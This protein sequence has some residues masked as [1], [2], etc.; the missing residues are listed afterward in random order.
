[1]RTRLLPLAV[2]ASLAPFALGSCVDAP[3]TLAIDCFTSLDPMNCAQGVKASCERLAPGSVFDIAIF[4]V[5]D[6]DGNPIVPPGVAGIASDG[7]IAFPVVSNHAH[8]TA[9]MG[10]VNGL[11]MN[12]KAFEVT[13]KPGPNAKTQN[14]AKLRTTFRVAVNGALLLPDTK[15]QYTVNVTVIP[16]SILKD[17][18]VKAA[19]DNSPDDGFPVVAELRPIADMA[20]S[21]IKGAPTTLGIKLVNG[22]LFSRVSCP[23]D[24]VDQSATSTGCILGQDLGS[25]CCTLNGSLVCGKAVP[26][27]Q[28]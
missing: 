2:T 5:V 14:I 23:A 4:D 20:G 16:A 21:E 19:I 7:Y 3:P 8:V 18:T 27:K 17:P 22:R 11:D 24:G 10:T 1:M 9:Q 25:T 12:L 28:Q 26:T 6:G 13:L 15:N